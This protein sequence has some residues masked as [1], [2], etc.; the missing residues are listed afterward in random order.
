MK[1]IE[2]K[3]KGWTKYFK[4]AVFLGLFLTIGGA[5][6]GLMTGWQPVTSG[7]V[8]AGVTVLLLWLVWMLTNAEGGWNPR[9]AEAGTN[10][11]VATVSVLVI[12][13][14]IN[15]LGVRYTERF[16]LTEN[17]RFTLAPQSQ[18]LVRNLPQPVK[19]WIFAGE[20]ERGDLELLQNYRRQAPNLF[21]FQ[22]VDPV[23]QPT[24]V[25]QFGVQSFGEVYLASE[26]GTRQQFVQTVSSVSPL[27]EARLTSSLEQFTSDRIYKVYFLQGHGERPLEPGRGAFSQAVA[28][29]Q[30][31]NFLVEP[32]NL[33]RLPRVPPDAAVVVIAGPRQPL[34]PQEVQALRT[35]LQ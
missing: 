12:L 21:S 18:Q 10:A 24:V 8:I 16:D 13:G 22:Y 2:T 7:L 29:L 31:K 4:Y 5:I 25:R 35:Y 14:I 26:D 15:F 17:Q 23:R 19:V 11:F 33:A 32:L 3:P 34:F 20:P 28:S 9:S 1:T 6:P 27:S 30:D